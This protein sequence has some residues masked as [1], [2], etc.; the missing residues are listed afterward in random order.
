MTRTILL[1]A[2]GL[3]GA[4]SASP[5]D[6]D[7]RDPWVRATIAGQSGTAAYLTVENRGGSDDRLV[8]VSSA[9][10]DAS[11]HSTSNENGVSRMRPLTDGLPIPAGATVQLRPGGNHIMLM[12]LR[13]PL[14]PGRA[15]TIRLTFERSGE[16]QV[17]VPVRDALTGAM[18]H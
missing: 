17:E 14:Q 2:A 6:L 15:I 18:N 16:R 3:L 12:G 10:A 1:I 4:C 11:L 7:V 8:G 5:P 9:S 13:E